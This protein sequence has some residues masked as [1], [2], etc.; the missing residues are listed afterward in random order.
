MINTVTNKVVR[1][2]GKD[3]ILR[4]LNLALFQGAPAK[5]G[6]QTLAMASSANPLL[7]EK[8]ERDP[9]LFATAWRKQRFYMFGRGEHDDKGTDRDVF[10]ERPT[11]DEAALTAAAAG[12]AEQKAKKVLPTEAT[13][14]TS[15]GDIHLKLFPHIAPK[16]VENF[17]THARNGELS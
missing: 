11:A 16:A 3:E 4:F 5:K 9:T 1:V 10:N 2:L 8:S 6:L 17:T 14:H 7:A 12:R 15:M 13:I